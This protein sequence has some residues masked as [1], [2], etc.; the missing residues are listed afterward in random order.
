MAANTA[1]LSVESL[2]GKDRIVVYLAPEAPEM[3][4]IISGDSDGDGNVNINDVTYLIDYLLTGGDG[5]G[6]G[7]DTDGD[8]KIDITDLTVLIDMILMGNN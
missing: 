4:E 8:G 1:W 3:P 2:S 7:A 6:A 5:A